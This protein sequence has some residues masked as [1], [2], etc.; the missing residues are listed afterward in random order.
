MA[1]PASA[2]G[3]LWFRRFEPAPDAQVRLVCLPHAGG[4]ASFYL[5]MARALGPAVEVLSAQYPGRQDRHH[6]PCIRDLGVLADELFAALG[7]WADRP[8][9]IF[10]HSMGAALGFELA[11]RIETAGAAELVRLFASGRP[12][13]SVQR[14]ENVHQRDDDGL[15]AELK[16][17][18]GTDSRVLDD[19]ELMEMALPAIRADYEAVETYRYADGPKLRCQ[20]TVLAGD[21]DPVAPLDEVRQWRAYT[22]AE[23]DFHIFP[24]GHFFLADHQDAVIGLIRDRLA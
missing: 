11:R 13:P 20:V 10:G 24:G 14:N 21:D 18:S 17:L 15:L 9:A 5:P 7:P 22:E 2:H 8:L 16:A 23:L 1:A 6:E 3:D 19:E 4:S 12:A